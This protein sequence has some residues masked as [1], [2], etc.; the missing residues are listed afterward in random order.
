MYLQVCS[1]SGHNI[2]NIEFLENNK[3]ELNMECTLM[4]DVCSVLRN[5]GSYPMKISI[6]LNKC[7]SIEDLVLRI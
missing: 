6:S 2:K 3:K 5:I 4:R 1:L 7:Y